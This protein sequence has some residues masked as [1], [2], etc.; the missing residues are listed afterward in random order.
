VIDI[1]AEDAE[2]QAFVDTWKGADGRNPRA[3]LGV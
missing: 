2:L 3:G 1:P